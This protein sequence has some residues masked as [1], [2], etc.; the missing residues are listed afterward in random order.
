MP[1]EKVSDFRQNFDPYDAYRRAAG[2]V[3]ARA[4]Q[5]RAGL[6]PEQAAIFSPDLDMAA[7][8]PKSKVDSSYSEPTC[9]HLGAPLMYVPGNNERIRLV[10]PRLSGSWQRDV[11]MLSV[12]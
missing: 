3:E 4:V 9:R 10:F 11:P 1:L 2:E 12:R 8:A 5:A 7:Q 6:T